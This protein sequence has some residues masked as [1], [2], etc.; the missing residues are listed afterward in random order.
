[1]LNYLIY[2]VSSVATDD[3]GLYLNLA[4]ATARIMYFG[5]GIN[6]PLGGKH[7]AGGGFRP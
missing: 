4:V 1:M 7:D 2:L 5:E 6:N 3:F